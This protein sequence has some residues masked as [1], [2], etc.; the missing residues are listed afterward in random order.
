MHV[1]TA[2]FAWLGDVVPKNGERCSLEGLDR[3]SGT[4]DR[5]MLAEGL[6]AALAHEIGLLGGFIG[7]DFV[8]PLVQAAWESTA[9]GP[10]R[11]EGDH[12]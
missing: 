5:E 7:E 1:A 3:V 9:I 6:A 8:M 4:M 10:A 2:E 11:I 12:E